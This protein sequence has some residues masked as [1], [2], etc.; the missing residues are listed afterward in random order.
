[1]KSVSELVAIGFDGAS[2]TFRADARAELVPVGKFFE[3]PVTTANGAVSVVAHE[4][5]IKVTRKSKSLAA[6]K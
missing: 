2:G 1:M 3:L 5:A 4:T 6:N